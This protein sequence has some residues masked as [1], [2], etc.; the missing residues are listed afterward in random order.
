MNAWNTIMR[1]QTQCDIH[2]D[3]MDAFWK[4]VD[5]KKYTLGDKFKL[6]QLMHRYYREEREQHRLYQKYHEIDPARLRDEEKEDDV[7]P[8]STQPPSPRATLDR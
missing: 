7:S 3:E 2:K 5:N 1:L 8:F 4:F 6:Q